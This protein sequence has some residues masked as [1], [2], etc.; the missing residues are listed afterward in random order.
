MPARILRVWR[1]ESAVGKRLRSPGQGSLVL[2][3]RLGFF[4]VL[5]V[6]S[7]PKMALDAMGSLRRM[8]N[9][10]GWGS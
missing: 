1:E 8:E 3:A 10:R 9:R 5:T 4:A 7:W 2:L 6:L